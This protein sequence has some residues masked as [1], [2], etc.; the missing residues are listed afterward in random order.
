[1]VKIGLE[2]TRANK[3]NKTGTEWYAW[4][5]FQ[6][7][8][9][10]DNTNKFF[11]YFNNDLSENLKEIPAN[12]Y[13]KRL[14]W[15]FKKFWTH[16]RL[17]IELIFY[18]VDKF[19]AS[20][21]LPL[22][23]R[24]EVILTVHDLG[25][26]K[27]P[28]LYHPLERIYQ[29]ISHIL[30]LKRANKIIAISK[31]T[32][33]DI[34][35]YFPKYKDKIKVIYNGYNSDSFKII[36]NNEKKEIREKYNLPLKYILYIGRLETKKNIQNLIKGY[37]LIKNKDIPL[38]LGGKPGNY[39]YNEIKELA[40]NEKNILFLGYIPQEDY[41]LLLASSFIFVFPS[42]F[43]GFGIPILEAMAS[44]TPIICSDIPVFK[45]ITED[46]VLLFNPDNIKDI[47]YIIDKIINN[48]KLRDQLIKKGLDQVKKFSWNKSAKEI[49]KY[50]LE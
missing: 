46:S 48:D 40:K 39:G 5:L 15:P 28:E 3:N 20:N 44:G 16:I 37:K 11:V 47:T 7:F 24:G 8:K 23:V 22:F 17:S 32:K 14:L 33:K 36:D 18:P 1:M 45:E 27:N 6:K 25:F 29:K 31:A 12:F 19:F 49:L 21:A 13:L 38:I 43:E 50:I 26:L 41:Q 2:I 34:I 9:E 4:Y 10:L 35:H 30:A 42:K